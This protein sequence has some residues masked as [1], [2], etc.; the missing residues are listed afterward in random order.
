MTRIKKRFYIYG[1][2]R[3]LGPGPHILHSWRFGVQ[4]TCPRGWLRC[5]YAY[6]SRAAEVCTGAERVSELLWLG[7]E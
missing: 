1:L 3:Q 2:N 5:A 7:H 4:C 6:V